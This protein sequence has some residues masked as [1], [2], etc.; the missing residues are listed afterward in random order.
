MHDGIMKLCFCLRG[1][2]NRQGDTRWWICIV[3]VASGC[4]ETSMDLHQCPCCTFGS[5]PGGVWGIGGDWCMLGMVLGIK[6]RPLF[7]IQMFSDFNAYDIYDLL[8]LHDGLFWRL[9]WNGFFPL[10]IGC[11]CVNKLL[12]VY[13]PYGYLIAFVTFYDFCSGHVFMSSWVTP[14]TCQ[15][16]IALWDD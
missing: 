8:W 7:S 6:K 3:F 12:M 11:V 2:G 4:L 14:V 5:Q 16:W 1:V 15:S 13:G 10:Y 9:P